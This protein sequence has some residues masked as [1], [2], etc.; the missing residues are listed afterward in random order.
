[1]HDSLVI[2]FDCF[3][4]LDPDSVSLVMDWHTIKYIFIV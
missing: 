1:M 3:A 2:L 4:L